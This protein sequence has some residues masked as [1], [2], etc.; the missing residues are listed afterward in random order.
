MGQFVLLEAMAANCVP[1]IVMDG[2]VMPF[3]DVIG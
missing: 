3:H 2:H 1:V